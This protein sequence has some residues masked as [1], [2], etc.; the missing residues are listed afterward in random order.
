MFERADSPVP[1]WI[2]MEIHE[3]RASWP[4]LA[5]HPPFHGLLASPV[6]IDGAPAA[7]LGDQLTRLA[8]RGH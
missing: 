2:G 4:L 8:A 1:I 7:P 5:A 6:T 3:F